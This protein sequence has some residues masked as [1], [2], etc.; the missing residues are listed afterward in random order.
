MRA[1]G[2]KTGE[3]G[4]AEETVQIEPGLAVDVVEEA[5]V[6]LLLVQDDEV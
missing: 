3:K 4:G 1:G 5:F 2:G 6:P